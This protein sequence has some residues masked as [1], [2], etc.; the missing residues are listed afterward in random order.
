MDKR[1]KQLEK[2]KIFGLKFEEEMEQRMDQ[3]HEAEL[4]LEQTQ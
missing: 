3:D 1:E 4:G 2:S